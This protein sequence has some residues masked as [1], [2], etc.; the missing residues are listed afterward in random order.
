MYGSPNGSL[1]KLSRC[2]T[3]QEVARYSYD[4]D[5]EGLFAGEKRSRIRI[6]PCSVDIDLVILSFVIVEKKKR[7]QAGDGT[8]RCPYD[9]DPLECGVDGGIGL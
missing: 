8:R 1:T 2:D 5:E 4:V 9:E 3:G 6:Q 7:D